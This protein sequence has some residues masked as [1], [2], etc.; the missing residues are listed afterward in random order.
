MTAAVNDV[1]FENKPSQGPCRLPVTAAS[2]QRSLVKLISFVFR[3]S[4][5]LFLQLILVRRTSAVFC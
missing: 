4:F 1:S 5:L 3:H 2:Q